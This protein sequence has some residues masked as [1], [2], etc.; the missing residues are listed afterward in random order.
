MRTLLSL[1]V[2]GSLLLAGCDRINDPIV[3]PTDNGNNGVT[4]TRK[5]LL[6]DYTGHRCPNCPDA[7]V[8]AGNLVDIYGD[9]LV[10]VGVH[11]TYDF[12]APEEPVQPD[13]GFTTDYRTPAGDAYENALGVNFLPNGS[14]SRRIFNNTL[15]QGEAAWSSA[16]ADIIGSEA[17]F[18]VWFSQLSYDAGSNTV[19]V[20]VKVAV[21]QDVTTNHNL[22]IYLTEDSIVDWQVVG[23]V[24]DPD[25]V[26]RHVLRTTVNGTWGVPLVNASHSVGDTLTLN[27][28]NFP[29]NAAW[30]A[31]HCALVAYVYGTDSYEVMQ[32]EEREFQ[33]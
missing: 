1:L 16:V 31:E 5:V 21:L 27:Y 32:V 3:A 22:T 15:L 29:V 10:V 20:E 19:D 33:P 28:P 11:C 17:A 8:V 13:G 25:Y 12:A 9:E 23:A 18:D 7:A 14:I 2:G 24:R 26:H 6:E 30:H 4:V